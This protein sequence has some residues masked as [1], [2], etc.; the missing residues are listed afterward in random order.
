MTHLAARYAGEFGVPPSRVMGSGTMLDTA[1]F[2]VLWGVAW[3]S[4][5]AYP[6]LRGRGAWRFGGVDLVT[7][8]CWWHATGRVLSPA[9]G[10]TGRAVRRQ[11]DDLVRNA[12]Y[13]IIEGKGSTYYGIGSALARIIDA[14]L[15]DQ[16]SILT[17]CT[18]V[19]EMAGVCDVTISLPHLLG[20]TAQWP[21]F[22]CRSARTNRPR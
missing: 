10:G 19:A 4:I 9:R 17:V 11:I 21:V 3:G 16:R 7:G 14:I 2:R 6:R 13:D 20:R 1:R 15:R 5:P 22:R 18:P 8:H 12:A